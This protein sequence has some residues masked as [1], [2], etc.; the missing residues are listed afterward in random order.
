MDLENNPVLRTAVTLC[1]VVRWTLPSGCLATVR[2]HAVHN[3]GGTAVAWCIIAVRGAEQFD[4]AEVS[5]IR[6]ILSSASAITSPCFLTVHS[7]LLNVISPLHVMA[8]PPP[9][10]LATPCSTLYICA[11]LFLCLC[12]AWS[13]FPTTLNV[14]E[15]SNLCLYLSDCSSER[16]QLKTKRG[17]WS[18]NS[19]FASSPG[20][21]SYI[22]FVMFTVSQCHI[23]DERY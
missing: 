16:R 17:I 15:S 21:M 1:L 3:C 12:H 22:F 19:R 7:F 5:C 11:G 10:I 8:K 2:I 4:I 6:G 14:P 9:S 13:S 23:C 20:R 18:N